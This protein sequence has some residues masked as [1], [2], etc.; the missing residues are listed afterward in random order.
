MKI[1]NKIS[2]IVPIFNAEMYLKRCIDSILNQT[3]VNLEILLINDGS[4]DNS[5]KICKEYAKQ[6]NRILY[7][8]QTNQGVSKT[9]N[10]GIEKSSG[11]FVC[12][13]DA[14]DWID[15]NFC[16]KLLN[17]MINTNS[18]LSV[19]GVN[20]V[21]YY[22]E[23]YA[24]EKYDQL[25]LSL[26]EVYKKMIIDKNFSGYLAN[27]MYKRDILLS[28]DQKPLDEEI[29][30]C[31]DY[32]MNT[33]YIKHC[34][35]IV[36]T[37]EKLYYYFRNDVSATKN[38]EFNTKRLTILDAYKKIINNYRQY[39]PSN[40]DYVI[41]EYIKAR[42]YVNYL[43]KINKAIIDYD[44]K[45]NEAFTLVINSKRIQINK[46]IYLFFSYKSPWIT[47]NIKEIIKKTKKLM[48]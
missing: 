13:V 24:E 15:K 44:Y 6:D 40:V 33:E 34:S 9:R 18:Q 45:D 20:S 42:I 12:F 19:C 36:Y 16:Y 10:N 28:I 23:L 41:Y 21:Q 11:E 46:K 30:Y 5:E 38:K 17:N 31:E 37:E 32:L 48:K 29:Y 1:S 35:N 25:K 43:I 2:I 3:Y 14:D 7:I 47:S 26:D 39:S 4:I 27:K 22:K 8:S